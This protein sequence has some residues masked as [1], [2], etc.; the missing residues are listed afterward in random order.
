MIRFE[1]LKNKLAMMKCLT[2]LTIEGFV[3]LL[4]AFETAFEADLTQRDE[5]RGRPR[6]RER[7]AGQKG[8]LPQIANKL[9]FILFYFRLYPVQMAQGFFFGMGQPQAN[10]WIHRLSPVLRAALGYD[11]QLPARQPQDIKA[12]LES[13]A[14]LWK[15]GPA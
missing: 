9:V 12:V 6:Q 5:Q 1:Q 13:C 11:L 8:T 10:E 4:P 15:V 7:G 2:G 3:T 14:G